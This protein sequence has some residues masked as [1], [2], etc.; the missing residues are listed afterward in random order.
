M[1]YRKLGFLIVNCLR[2]GFFVID[3]RGLRVKKERGKVM[4][5]C[6]LSFLCL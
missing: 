1:N 2:L 3:F 6:H 5:G 4:D